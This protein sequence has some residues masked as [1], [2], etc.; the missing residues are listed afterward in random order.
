MIVDPI[1]TRAPGEGVT[2]SSVPG[3]TCAFGR[4]S[5]TGAKPAR[6]RASA[7]APASRPSTEG[8]GRLGGPVETTSCTWAGRFTR[9]PAAG[10]VSTACHP[11]ISVEGA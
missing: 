11:S 6:W 7:A 2:R 3:S 8:T 4:S 9:V 10:S 1:A 5:T